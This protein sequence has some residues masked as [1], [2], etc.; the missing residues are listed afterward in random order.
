VHNSGLTSRR[1]SGILSVLGTWNRSSERGVCMGNANSG[2]TYITPLF[3]GLSVPSSSDKPKG[4]FLMSLSKNKRF[5][6]FARDGFTCQYCGQ[7]PPDVVLEVDHVHPVSKG[8][9]DDPLNLI[10]ACYDCNRGKCAKVLKDIAPKPD[11]DAAF[12]KVQQ[13]MAELRRFLEAKEERDALRQEVVE[14]LQGVWYDANKVDY[15]PND[16]TVI[17]WLE[18]YPPEEIETA[19]RITA[20]A[21]AYRSTIWLEKNVSQMSRYTAGVLRN[22]SQQVE[23]CPEQD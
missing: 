3:G 11:A 2:I 10:T 23:P 16:T 6:I 5:T 13:E 17:L 22:R 12:L 20:R 14:Y 15:A 1:V 7:R 4:G 9:G 8:G 21:N 19:I 18:R